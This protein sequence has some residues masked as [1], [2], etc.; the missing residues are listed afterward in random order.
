LIARTVAEHPTLGAL[1]VH[2]GELLT[3]HQSSKSIR[4]VRSR[5][6]KSRTARAFP[7]ALGKCFTNQRWR[8]AGSSSGSRWAAP[9]CQ[10]D[11]SPWRSFSR[12]LE[13]EVMLRM[14]PAF[15]PCSA[16]SQNCLSTR[17][18]PTGVRR[19][20]PL[21]RPMV[22]RRAYPGTARPTVSTNLRGGLKRYFC[23][24]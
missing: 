23:N 22:S 20:F 19:G 8:S 24:A 7:A 15:M 3:R 6:P 9:A 21:L 11:L 18:T 4:T 14:Y 10:R 2:H 17:P 16:T 12:T 5:V 1:R 13:L